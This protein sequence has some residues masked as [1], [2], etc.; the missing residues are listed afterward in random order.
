MY[1]ILPMLR[2]ECVRSYKVPDSDLIIE[3]GTLILIPVVGLHK[4][5]K[6]YPEPSQFNPER[7]E[8]N[9]FKP[10]STF[11]PFGDGPRI[12]IAMRFAVMEVKA[13]VSRIMSQYSVKLSHKTQLPLQFEI[14]SFVPIIRGG[15]FLVFEKR[16]PKPVLP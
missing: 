7:F 11:L 1:P 13:C 14:R 9:N 8:G 6:H 16:L 4:D 10:S 5:P 12:C 3:K 2:R 15:L